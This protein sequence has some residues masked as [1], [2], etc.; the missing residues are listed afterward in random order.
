MTLVTPVIFMDG[1]LKGQIK[2]V[3]FWIM[4]ERFK[5]FKR[6]QMVVDSEE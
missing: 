3:K 2:D 1:T 6:K 5:Q 4:G